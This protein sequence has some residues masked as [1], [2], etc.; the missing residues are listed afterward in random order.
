MPPFANPGI[1][2]FSAQ[3][4]M[5]TPVENISKS[6]YFQKIGV[7]TRNCPSQ[8]AAL[9]QPPFSGP[10]SDHLDEQNPCFGIGEP[11]GGCDCLVFYPRQHYLII[12]IRSGTQARKIS[13]AG[14]YITE[15]QMFPEKSKKN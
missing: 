7:L 14:F 3:E 15:P 12:K 13:A 9:Q 2:F 1:L 8:I 4:I 11:S 6:T 5:S 10:P